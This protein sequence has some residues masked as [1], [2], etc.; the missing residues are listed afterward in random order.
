MPVDRSIESIY[1]QFWLCIRFFLLLIYGIL[2]HF[3]GA[4]IA[5]VGNYIRY[6]VLS[7]FLLWV[8]S[9]LLGL[10]SYI[11][12]DITRCSQLKIN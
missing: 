12:Y 4:Y 8:M 3:L 7:S 6:V 2:Y 1:I 11:F 5:D 10:K 9:G